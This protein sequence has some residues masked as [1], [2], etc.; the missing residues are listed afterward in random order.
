[1][2]KLLGRDP[3][4]KLIERAGTKIREYERNVKAVPAP[5]IYFRCPNK[6]LKARII[7]VASCQI[8]K[9][10]FHPNHKPQRKGV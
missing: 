9:C 6:M 8:T 1:M 10:E 3:V 5:P 4:M 2:K 7:C